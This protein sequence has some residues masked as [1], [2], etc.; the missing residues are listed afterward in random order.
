[1]VETF[2]EQAARLRHR[3]VSSYRRAIEDWKTEPRSAV[4][5]LVQPNGRTTPA[6]FCLMRVDIISG[7]STAPRITR[8]A[9]SLEETGG[10]VTFQLSSGIQVQQHSFSWEALRLRFSG[11]QF[12]IE[13]L[14][15]WLTR[16]LDADEVREPD[17]SG[18]SGVV[19]DL[20]WAVEDGTWQL[21]VDFGSAPIE[22]LKDLLSAISAVGVTSLELSRHDAGDA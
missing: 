19:H 3:Y 6:P 21:D 12:R 20:A 1:M 4:E 15:G 18:L 14:Q 2:F 16:W 13:G 10:S 11:S 8:I 17:A 5:L 9:D 22:A 7:D